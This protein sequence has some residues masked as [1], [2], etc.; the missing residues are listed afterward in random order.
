MKTKIRKIISIILVLVMITPFIACDA[1]KPIKISK[2]GIAEWKAVKGAVKYHVDIC[3]NYGDDFSIEYTFDTT[4]TSVRLTKGVFIQVTPIA[5]DGSYMNMMSSSYYGEIDEYDGKLIVVEED[6]WASWYDIA[7]VEKYIVTYCNYF[8]GDPNE[9]RTIEVYTNRLEMAEGFYISVNPVFKSGECGNA[10]I[11]TTW[12]E[13]NT[14]GI[15]YDVKIDENGIASWEAVKNAT[16]YQVDYIMIDDEGVP[17]VSKTKYTT[18]TS[19]KTKPGFS[20]YVTP[21]FEDGSI[22][23]TLLSKVWGESEDDDWYD[24]E[25]DSNG[26]A[27]WDKVEGATSYEVELIYKE[28]EVVTIERTVGVV[29]NSI[30]IWPGYKVVVTPAMSDGS[31]GE[32]MKSDYWGTFDQLSFYSDKNYDIP[33]EKLVVWN[34]IENIDLSSVKK[35]GKDVYFSSNTPEGDTIRFWGYDIDVE[36]NGIVFHEMGKIMSLDSPGRIMKATNIVSDPGDS[37]NFQTMYGGYDVTGNMK[38]GNMDN[39]VFTCSSGV[40]TRN[41]FEEGEDYR[42]TF[43]DT[44]P[45]FVGLGTGSPEYD[46]TDYKNKDSSTTEEFK[47]TYLPDNIP[48]KIKAVRINE[49]YYGYYF[50]GEKYQKDKEGKYDPENGVID[51][52]LTGIPELVGEKYPRTEADYKNGNELFK[53][54]ANISYGEHYKI[55]N[56]KDKNGKV[57]N[58]DTATYQEGETLEIILGNT[59]YDMPLSVYPRYYG[60]NTMHDLV[61]DAYPKA[62]GEMTVLVVPISWADEDYNATEEEYNNIKAQ[63]G[64]VIENGTVNDYSSKL[65]GKYSLSEYYDTASYNKLKINSFLT[66]WYHS[67]ENFS[68]IREKDAGDDFQKKVLEWVYDTYPDLDISKFDRNADGYIDAAVFIN[69]GDMSRSNGYNIMSFEGAVCIRNTYGIESAGSLRHPKLNSF[70]NM[71]SMHFKDNT[72]I[73]EFGHVLGLIDYYDVT[74]SGIDAVGG[75]DMQSESYGDWNVYSKYSVGWIEPTVIGDLKKGQSKEIT[76]GSFA[77]TGDA[78]IVPIAGSK[79]NGP[80]AE[81]MAVDLFTP[82]GNN[83]Y[84][85]KRYGLQNT[86]GVRIYHVD[87]RM[88]KRDYVSLNHRNI[89][90]RPIGTIHFANNYKPEGKYNIEL[91]QAGGVNTFTDKTKLR[92]T[93]NDSDFFKQGSTFT[94]DKFSEFFCDGRMDEGSNLGYKIEVVSITGTGKDAKAVIKVTRE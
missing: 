44:Q 62:E 57:L 46:V 42:G 74:Y 28:D 78:I 52:S 5:E 51:F 86:T 63:L 31:M 50:E 21:I 82:T 80:F 73:H 14:D 93:I 89:P 6:G 2:D 60:A 58:K 38:P 68:E 47:V 90:S 91:I 65:N 29:D 72:L 24:V 20:V 8:D 18:D 43:Y 92:A 17:V 22:G 66:D 41:Y 54:G 64:R 13:P 88:E 7:D 10:L 45:N 94:M 30:Q 27:R 16:S 12:G 11:S 9:V 53:L 33:S 83:T 48:T 25:V 81:Y 67:E 4:E 70:V 76:I 87:A 61:P 55:G 32:T 49:G 79:D 40:Y 3:H 26:I 77:E 85:A 84:D 36:E 35:E 71:N 37:S 69:I 59:T 39:M 15:F 1:G 19:I 23:D 75:Y 34:V 56:L